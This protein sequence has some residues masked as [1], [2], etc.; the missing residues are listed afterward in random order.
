MGQGNWGFLLNS[1]GV[2]QKLINS[3]SNLT[4]EKALFSGR[5]IKYKFLRQRSREHK[6]RGKAWLL[7]AILLCRRASICLQLGCLWF[8]GVCLKIN[9]LLYAI[10]RYFLRGKFRF[11]LYSGTI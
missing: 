7:L 2:K 6:F 4:V 10:F 3:D 9:V 8:Y 1:M 5:Q 11:S